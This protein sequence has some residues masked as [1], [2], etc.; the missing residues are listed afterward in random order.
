MH[1][2][3][4]GAGITGLAAAVELR[5]RGATV[6]VLEAAPRVG[7]V[8]T[9]IDREGWL[10][11]AGPTS[12]TATAQLE[13]LIDQLGLGSERISTS[14]AA[15]RRY[16]VRD[17]ALV[18]LPDGPG[19][20]AGTRAI[21]ARAKLALLREPFVRAR[22]D[23]D[24]ES[25]ADLVRRRL[26]SEI[27]DYLVN[28]LVAGIYAGDPE[29]LSVRYAMPMLYDGERK[30]G[31]LIMGAMKEMKA[32]RGVVRQRGITSFVHGLRTLPEA[33]AAY[34]GESVRT[35]TRVTRVEQHGTGWRLSCGGAMP[36][37]ID[38]DAVLCT[39]PSYRLATLGLP[40]EVRGALGPIARLHHPPVATLALGFR[41]EDI[42]HPLDG[43]GVLMPA[44]EKRTVLGVLFSSSVF[45]GRAPA[46]HVLLT[47]FLG[48]LRS[49]EHGNAE[50][51]E[52]LP[53]VLAD[54]RALLGVRG[55]PV[56]INHQRWATAIP[57]YELGHE[58][59]VNAAASIE[60]A[61]PGLYLTGQWRGGVALGDCIAQGQAT[62]ARLVSER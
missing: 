62:A 36:T 10:V 13:G 27:L 60:S 14:E 31:S 34:L 5:G 22:R 48:G 28:P 21:S 17:G 56:F 6:T 57:Q 40:D 16:I 45:A 51:T 20:L 55:D 26:D 39:A 11:E 30:H 52:A 24:D 12:L 23:R 47:C 49:P 43:F 29:R 1:V 41:Q 19:S 50:L 61:L 15:K 53:L 7:G 46:G 8:I 37:T 33:M 18:A 38:A 4:I 59:V 32:K 58:L 35:S 42:E 25:L 9:T 3:V 2:A 54:L 44:V